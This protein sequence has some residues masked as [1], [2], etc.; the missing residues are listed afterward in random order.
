[1]QG[2]LEDRPI[3]TKT[4]CFDP[5]PFPDPLEAQ[6]AAIANLAERLDATRRTALAENP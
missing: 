5:F 2:T 1:M 6:R 3:Y 4:N